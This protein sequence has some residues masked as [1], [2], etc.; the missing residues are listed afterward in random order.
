MAPKWKEI[1][2]LH[3]KM[4]VT[5]MTF[6]I[7][8]CSTVWNIPSL[9]DS[10][11]ILASDNQRRFRYK[12]SSRRWYKSYKLSGY[13]INQEFMIQCLGGSYNLLLP[14]Y[15]SGKYMSLP[16]LK[17]DYLVA[18]RTS[19]G[20][21]YKMG[22][23]FTPPIN[24]R[25]DHCSC[26]QLERSWA[27]QELLKGLKLLNYWIK[28][29]S[30]NSWWFPFTKTSSA[31]PAEVAK[32]SQ[33]PPH[34]DYLLLPLK[35]EDRHF[36]TKKITKKRCGVLHQYISYFFALSS[37][38]SFFPRM[39]PSFIVGSWFCSTGVDAATLEWSPGHCPKKRIPGSTR[40]HTYSFQNPGF[41]MVQN[42]QSQQ[43]HGIW[44]SRRK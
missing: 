1:L 39:I 6:W 43:C 18:H 29:H 15:M 30:N 2:H 3:Q 34:Q 24:Q 17:D 9:G 19:S 25:S 28:Q 13:T 7:H 26:F 12:G 27:I 31:W 44:K 38:P 37:T 21:C 11:Q 40:N 14:W 35:K 36:P 16:L 20:T 8:R 32:F 10:A 22:T 42:S 5:W 41:W 23:N 33:L 4:S